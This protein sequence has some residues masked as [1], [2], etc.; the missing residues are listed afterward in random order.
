MECEIEVVECFF[1]SDCGFDGF[2]GENVC[3]GNNVANQYVN[4]TCENAGDFNS[5]CFSEVENLNIEECSFACFGGFCI[6][7]GCGNGILE[8][9]EECDDNNLFNGDGC[10]SECVLE[11]SLCGNDQCETQENCGSCSVDCGICNDIP[12]THQVI[13]T[14]PNPWFQSVG[15]ID[16]DGFNDVVVG[17]SLDG[18]LRWY[19]YPDWSVTELSISLNSVDSE[20]GDVDNDGDLDIIVGKVKWLENPGIL[21]NPFDAS[22][23]VAH[24]IG[25][26]PTH[27]VVVGDLDN[28]ND[29]D[30]IVRHQG[31]EGN[32]IA[33]F[34]QIN[35]DSWTKHI[36]IADRGEGI[37]LGDVDNDGDIDIVIG[38][39][40]YENPG[41]INSAWVQRIFDTDWVENA[42]VNTADLNNDGRTDL[43]LSSATGVGFK[44]SWFEGPFDPS[45]NGEWVEHEI[46][47]SVSGAH[48][49]E[50]ADMDLDGDL[51]V[52]TAETHGQKRVIVYRNGGN[53][54]NWI[55]QVISY[56]GSHNI[57]V[58]DIGNDGDFDIV[59][60]QAFGASNPIDLWENQI[61]VVRPRRVLV[62]D[63]QRDANAAHSSIPFAK[64]LVSQLGIDNNYEVV[65]SNDASEFT[66]EN[67]DNY[68]TVIFLLTTSHSG[69]PLTGPNE[70]GFSSG[71]LNY[72]QEQAFEAYILSGGGFVGVHSGS[73]ATAYE[74]PWFWQNLVGARFKNHPPQQIADVVV[75]DYSH[76][77]TS[78]MQGN[79]GIINDIW[80]REDEWYNMRENP[81]DDSKNV[82]LLSVDETSY[83]GGD[84]IDHPVTWYKYLGSG[85]SWSTLMGHT[86]SSYASDE[87]FKQHLSGGI[88]FA[89]GN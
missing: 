11:S 64:S 51:D 53:G 6:D 47:N 8:V 58:R 34:E 27:S 59:G 87:L 21:G 54:Q 48:G 50:I 2:V 73:V 66:S 70:P 13:D 38:G 5:S 33:V 25:S 24:F 20:L 79:P 17:S 41:V 1:E 65:F 55:E 68:G 67:L 76:I 30:V 39:E 88:L 16:G 3:I 82:I 57:Q 12:I 29:L 86:G 4:Y 85:R 15:D 49:I 83:S 72:D 19:H 43:I 60:S 14:M 46:A 31:T 10:S 84:M 37:E 44:V 61:S 23:W 42:A 89:L 52:I 45:N 36:L 62:F 32:I 80:I 40:W 9:G 26:Q 78:F 69:A 7:P 56:D 81:R 22:Q 74:W 75:E 28:D 63:K 18:I 71:L 77:S 35:P